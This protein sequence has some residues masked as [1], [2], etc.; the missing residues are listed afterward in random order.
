MMKDISIWGTAGMS[1][2]EKYRHFKDVFGPM[3]RQF[4]PRRI[5]APQGY[6]NPIEYAIQA[7]Y[8]MATYI[9]QPTSIASDVDN[10]IHA[11]AVL[12]Q[13]YSWP[14]YFVSE[15]FIS[16]VAATNPPEN[17][18]LEDINWPLEF[19]LLC[20][21]TAW[22]SRYLDGVCTFP[23]LTVAHQPRGVTKTGM[24][25]IEAVSDM[26]LFTFPLFNDTPVAVG[27]GAW[28]P[29]NRNVNSFQDAPF[30]QPP[31]DVTLERV[32]DFITKTALTPEQDKMIAT[33]MGNLAVKLLLVL[34]SA[35]EY[36]ERESSPARTAK[37]S[38]GVEVKSELWNPNWL[39]RRYRAIRDSAAPVDGT[40]A[41]P[42]MHWRMGH[43]RN[44]PWG[45]GRAK[46]KLIWIQPVLVKGT[47]D[48]H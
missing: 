13:K 27:Y 48:N 22:V 21:P 17:C 39:G 19:M 5:A 32:P 15:E 41:S 3:H 20:L 4:Y 23:F 43:M 34:N 12:G 24:G 26:A 31:A 47:T 30:L 10:T 14:T 44:Q 38:K 29:L 8:Q 42:V 46:R 16:A 2:K 36:L 7:A 9:D 11:T 18:T 33:R 45:A 40:H 6:T 35:P 25:E 28:Q 37:I 1:A